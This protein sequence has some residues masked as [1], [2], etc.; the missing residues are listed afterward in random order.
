MSFPEEE[1]GKKMSVLLRI[2]PGFVLEEVKL[3]QNEDENWRT[4]L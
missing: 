1:V 2:W 3:Q 4:G